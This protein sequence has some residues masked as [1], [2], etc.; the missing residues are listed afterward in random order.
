MLERLYL[1]LDRMSKPWTCAVLGCIAVGLVFT[2]NFIDLSWTLRGFER[3]TGG[4]GIL[5]M[6]WHY[7][8]A[9]A[10]NVLA[11]QGSVGRAAY[12]RMLWSLD[13]AIPPSVA[14]WL[15]T[16]I[17]LEARRLSHWGTLLRTLSLIPVLAGTAD[18]IENSLISCL[19]R[20]YPTRHPQLAALAGWVT[21]TK[22]LLYGSSLII[23]GAGLV[24]V[25]YQ[26]YKQNRTRSSELQC[27]AADV[28]SPSPRK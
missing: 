10:Y 2:A 6:R 13:L 8:A 1:W 5:D 26:T 16:A 3:L 4:V 21:T 7:D 25:L 11:R 15:A 24:A 27:G 28:R 22:Q 17:T 9:T 14:L 19:L 23:A 18:F 20:Y 12:L